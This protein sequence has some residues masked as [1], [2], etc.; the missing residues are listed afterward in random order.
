[1]ALL[2][3]SPVYG[4]AN[5]DDGKRLPSG[6]HESG[7]E[8]ALG[9]RLTGSVQAPVVS[10]RAG[11]LAVGGDE[12]D[13]RGT[14]RFLQQEMVVLNL[15]GAVVSLLARDF[16]SFVGGDVRDLAAGARPPGKLLDARG[17][18][19]ELPASPPAI[20]RTKI[21]ALPSTVA[22]KASRPHRGTSAAGSSPGG[23]A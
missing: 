2:S 3:E 13:V 1:M 10:L 8:G 7:D 12:P 16:G 6:D 18:F 15:E 9:G 17:R 14:R 19:G 4:V 23:C 21:C 11:T 20:G 22:R 5:P